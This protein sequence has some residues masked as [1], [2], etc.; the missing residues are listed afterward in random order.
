MARWAVYMAGGRWP[1]QLG[2]VTAPT[3]Q[4]ALVKATQ[5]FKVSPERKDQVIIA[6]LDEKT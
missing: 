6:L 4:L 2:I 5:L 3:Q 1:K